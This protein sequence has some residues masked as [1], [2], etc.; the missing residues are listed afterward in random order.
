MTHP[1]LHPESDQSLDT[2]ALLLR[3]LSTIT[4]LEWEGPHHRRMLAAVDGFL[5]RAGGTSAGE[6]L[7][8]LEPGRPE[9]DGLLDLVTVGETYFFRDQAQ[10][11]LVGP[12]VR[13]ALASPFRTDSRVRV[14]SAG[15]ATGEEPYTLAMV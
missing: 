12:T 10:L 15:C 4:G 14:W 1:F 8:C 6:L 7:S 11:E 13:A 3:H 5:R 2:R 9:L